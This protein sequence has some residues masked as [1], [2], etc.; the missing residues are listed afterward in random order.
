MTEY[1]FLSD[2]NL[3]FSMESSKGVLL[4]DKNMTASKSVYNKL[5][6]LNS[7]KAPGSDG[8]ANWVLKEY[9]EI[10][11]SFTYFKFDKCIICRNKVATGLEACKP[12]YI[13]HSG[14]IQNR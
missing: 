10:L 13:T 12:I 11:C 3:Q 9:A 7:A 14:A 2:H 5:K 8:K 6:L 1:T 4:A